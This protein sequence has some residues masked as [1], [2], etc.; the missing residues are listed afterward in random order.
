LMDRV[1]NF[2]E[3]LHLSE[4]VDVDLEVLYFTEHG[5]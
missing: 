2:I 4:V 5:H 1:V 3:D